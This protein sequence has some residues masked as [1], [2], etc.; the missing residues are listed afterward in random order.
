MIIARE[1]NCCLKVLW[2]CIDGAMDSVW[3]AKVEVSVSWQGRD[4]QKLVKMNLGSWLS[5]WP[6]GLAHLVQV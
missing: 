3:K 4:K 6:V 1:A 5:L 2:E